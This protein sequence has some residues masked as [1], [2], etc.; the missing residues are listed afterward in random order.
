MEKLEFS[1]MGNKRCFLFEEA[2]K[3]SLTIKRYNWRIANR[4]VA[5]G[6]G[7]CLRILSHGERRELIKEYEQVYLNNSLVD[8]VESYS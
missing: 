1:L 4:I 8:L 7:F 6:L 5:K 2:I 3:Y